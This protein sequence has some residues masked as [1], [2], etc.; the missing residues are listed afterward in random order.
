MRQNQ[1]NATAKS[2]HEAGTEAHL[3]RPATDSIVDLL[4]SLPAEAGAP[5]DADAIDRAL[6]HQLQAKLADRMRSLIGEDGELD[7]A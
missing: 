2:L 4:L 7:A 1:E 6:I 5:V 3:S